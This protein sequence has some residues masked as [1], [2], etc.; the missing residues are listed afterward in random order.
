[1][2]IT[3][4]R[5]G[6][7]KGTVPYANVVNLSPRDELVRE[8]KRHVGHV[9]RCSRDR[10]IVGGYSVETIALRCDDC[11]EVILEGQ[12]RVRKGGASKC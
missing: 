6:I 1:V 9:L 2:R 4:E 3:E 12:A 11:G 8:L 10:T 5:G 7:V